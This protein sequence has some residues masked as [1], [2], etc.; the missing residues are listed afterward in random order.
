MENV[1]N[2]VA[3][4]AKNLIPDNQD[5]EFELY[6]AQLDMEVDVRRKISRP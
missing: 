3:S 2:I 1:T 6:K 4:A 5:I